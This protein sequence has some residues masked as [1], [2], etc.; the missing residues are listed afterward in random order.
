MA[1]QYQLSPSQLEAY[2]ADSF[3]LVPGL[4]GELGLRVEDVS[5]WAE[6]IAAWPRAPGKYIQHWEEVE[7]GARQFCRAENFAR[8]HGGMAGLTGALNDVVGQLFGEEAVLFKEKINYKLAGGAGFNP[9][10]DTA[11]Y[12]LPGMPTA[13]ISVMVA[14]DDATPENGCLQVARGRWQ[15]GDVQL[16]PDGVIAPEEEEAMAFEDVLWKAGDVMFFSGW[17]PHRS[18]RNR[19]TRARRAVYITYNPASHGDHHNAYYRMKHQKSFGHGAG[20]GKISFINDFGGKLV[21]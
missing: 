19:S 21:E 10:Q 4:L 8:Y 18:F 2:E 5:G 12:L 9:H 3:L 11:A 20:S 14:L 15:Q 7:G 13:H 6:E 17:I 1:A 16:T